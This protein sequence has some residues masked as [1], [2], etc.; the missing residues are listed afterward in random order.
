MFKEMSTEETFSVEGGVVEWAA[1]LG[2]LAL[3]M[4]I[5]WT[6]VTANEYVIRETGQSIKDHGADLIDA[7]VEGIS[8]DF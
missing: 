3:G 8:L 4:L 2:C 5:S 7:G 1:I 6:Y